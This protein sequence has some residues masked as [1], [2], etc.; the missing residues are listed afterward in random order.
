[1]KNNNKIGDINKVEENEV[2]ADDIEKNINN[3]IDENNI[4][5]EK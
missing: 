3:K 5:N 4:N 1:M 2:V